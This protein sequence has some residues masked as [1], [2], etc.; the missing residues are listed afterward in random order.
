MLIES[1]TSAPPP[2]SCPHCVSFLLFR[3]RD[4]RACNRQCEFAGDKKQ[5]YTRGFLHG[6][7]RRLPYGLCYSS[8]RPQTMAIWQVRQAKANSQ[9]FQV[10]FGLS[11]D[12]PLP[13]FLSAALVGTHATQHHSIFFG[14][15][16]VMLAILGYLNRCSPFFPFLLSKHKES[17]L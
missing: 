5:L 15:V 9:T 7:E 16:L 10:D 13:P 3:Q 8:P 17:T 4:S 14:F 1:I 11:G 6:F 12:V 2:T